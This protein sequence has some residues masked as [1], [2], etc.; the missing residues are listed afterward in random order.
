MN[1]GKQ[2]INS[3]LPD[4]FEKKLDKN[5]LA[6]VNIERIAI[7]QRGQLGSFYEVYTDNITGKL[8]VKIAAQ[9][10]YKAIRHKYTYVQHCKHNARNLLESVGIDPQLR[11]SILLEMTV[12]DGIASLIH[13]SQSID[14]Y[15]RFFICTASHTQTPVEKMSTN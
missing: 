3:I 5:E 2:F 1:L 9:V 13:Y 8:N 14:E 15:T 12:A 4:V 6:V 11:L 7:D 10:Q